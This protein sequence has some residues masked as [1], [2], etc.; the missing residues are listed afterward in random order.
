MIVLLSV[1]QI[2]LM[3]SAEAKPVDAPANQIQFVVGDMCSSVLG[4]TLIIVIAMGQDQQ[5]PTECFHPGACR[6][7]KQAR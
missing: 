7:N 3:G 2:M 6:L 4:I 1:L 5:P